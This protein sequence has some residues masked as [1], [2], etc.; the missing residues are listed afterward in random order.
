MNRFIL[1]IIYGAYIGSPEGST[2]I[3]TSKSLEGLL[4]GDWLGYS[5]F[6]D[7]GT[8]VGNELGLS[9]DNVFGTTLVYLDVIS[10]GT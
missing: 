8:Y 4:I 10:L 6:N 9:D 3:T 7:I 1:S 2:E 5:Y